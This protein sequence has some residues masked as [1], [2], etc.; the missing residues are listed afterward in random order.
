MGL[1]L[2]LLLLVLDVSHRLHLQPPKV[3]VTRVQITKFFGADLG[4]PH[5][6]SAGAD[7][8]AAVPRTT[9]AGLLSEILT[10]WGGPEALVDIRPSAVATTDRI[11]AENDFLDIVKNAPSSCSTRRTVRDYG[12]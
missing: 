12:R 1:Q 3:L 2:E 8:S 5:T 11:S 10:V 4:P 7:T 6:P 9:S